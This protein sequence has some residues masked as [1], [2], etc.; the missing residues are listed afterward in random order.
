MAPDE[1]DQL[2]QA[3]VRWVREPVATLVP[4]EDE[5]AARLARSGRLLRFDTMY[6][7]LGLRGRSEHATRIGAHHDQDGMLLV[8]NHQRTNVPGLYAVGDVV[9]GLTQI[10]VARGQAAV[11]AST[12]NGSLDRRLHPS[13]PLPSALS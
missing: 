11:A 8:D 4:G 10:G 9:K 6:S 12:I 7:A 3:G 2:K 13:R 5:M 1:Y